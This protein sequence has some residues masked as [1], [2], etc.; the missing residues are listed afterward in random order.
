MR[1]SILLV[2]GLALLVLAF[3]TQSR[4][5]ACPA[6]GY[7]SGCN[8][9][10]TFSGGSTV[11]TT[12]GDPNAYDGVEDQLVGVVNNSGST[13]NSITLSGA[14][15]FGFDGDGAGEPGVGCT[16]DLTGGTHGCLST[17]PFGPSG[18]EGPNTSFTIVDGNDGTVH[19]TG[20]L[21]NGSTAW[22][23]LEEPASLT[24]FGVT[25][26]STGTPEPSSLVLLGSGFLSLL[27]LARRRLA[28]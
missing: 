23:S 10:I 15:I 5:D 22:F 24:N 2:A 27:G 1:K 17:G 8:L 12:L 19:F 4:A 25:G 6:I 11:N 13:L 26:V 16:V 14:N 7:A 28:S 18:Y 21:A 3:P 9:T 20:G